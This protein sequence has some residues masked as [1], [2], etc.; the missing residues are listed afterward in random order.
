VPLANSR[1]RT[2]VRSRLPVVQRKPKAVAVTLAA[3]VVLSG[4]GWGAFAIRTGRHAAAPGPPTSAPSSGR[5]QPPSIS[6]SS[7][8]FRA[9]LGP[10]CLVHEVHGDVDGDGKADSAFTWTP[11]PSG[12]CPSDPPFGP[13]LLTVFR[14]RNGQ[15][16]E[17]RITDRC[18]GQ[19]CGYLAKSDLNGDGRSE[20]AAVTWTGAA[21]DFYRLFGL[22]GEKLVALPVARPGAK[23]FP[24]AAPL[25][26]DIGGSVLLQSFVTCERSDTWKGI[27]LLA[28]GFAARVD[29]QGVVR[30][31]HSET[32][33]RFTGRAFVVL[34]QDPSEGF[35][36]SYDPARDPTLR[37]RKCWRTP[38]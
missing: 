28:H 5:P 11:E 35:P 4:L 24:G 27:V 3:A 32:G 2:G 10:A 15:R 22:V 36:A 19:N 38:S 29:D 17:A 25:E 7:I 26:L 16:V 33:F 8:G 1:N 12:G 21:D 30:W 34:Y 18:D 13:F 23:G 37:A 14:A 9:A 31:R 6:P 20:L